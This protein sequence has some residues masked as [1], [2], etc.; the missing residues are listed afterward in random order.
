MTS[1]PSPPIS[2]VVAVAAGQG[3]VARAAVDGDVDQGGEAVAGRERVVA[4]VGVDDQILGGADVEA[5]G[6]RADAV[7][8]DAGAVGGRS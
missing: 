7:E 6:G 3:V 4:A 5:E 1:L 8:A 2:D